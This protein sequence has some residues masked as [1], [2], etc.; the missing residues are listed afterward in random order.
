MPKTYFIGDVH[1][2]CRT[3][4]KLVTEK[5]KP[6]KEDLLYF[7][8]DYIDRGPDSKEV[9]DYILELQMEGFNVVTLRGNHEQM[10]L[11]SREGGRYLLL[12]LMN[13][14]DK[15]LRSFGVESVN[16]IPGRYMRFFEQTRMYVDAGRFIAVHAGLDFRLPDPF[17]DP[18][19][20]LWIRNFPVDNSFLGERLLIHG[21]TP[22]ELDYILSQKLR[23]SVNI[24]GGCVYHWLPGM[25]H[26][27]ALSL[28]DEKFC[29]VEYEG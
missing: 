1:G 29:V 11:D 2:C 10:L 3:L 12:W 7:I 21:H 5:I 20:M 6:V 9:V 4:K 23:S 14:G 28:E 24:D 16:D 25:G 15:T 22:R 27:V 17:S 18:E 19:S 8:G 13:G 26:L